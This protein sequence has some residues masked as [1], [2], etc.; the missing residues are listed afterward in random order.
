M[1]NDI[2]KFI[3][4]SEEMFSIIVYAGLS[5]CIFLGL[6]IGLAKIGDK[7]GRKK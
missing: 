2:L 6:A 4:I 5:A 7:H 3:G 1:L